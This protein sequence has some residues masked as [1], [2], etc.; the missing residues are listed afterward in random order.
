MSIDEDWTTVE[1]IIAHRKED[2]RTQ[3]LTKWK[4]L[5]YSEATWEDESDLQ[6]DKVG[7][8]LL[9]TVAPEQCL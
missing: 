2:G 8:V 9:P 1:R 4:G 6:D 5:E 7:W 3:Y